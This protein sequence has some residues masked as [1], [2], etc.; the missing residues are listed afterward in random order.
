MDRIQTAIQTIKSGGIIVVSDDENRENEGDFVM[1][2]EAATPEK[3]GFINRHSSGII[4]APIT[5]AKRRSLDLPMMVARNTDPKHTAFTV[6]LDYRHGTSTGISAADRA[7]TLNA[8]TRVSS[9]P[10]DF[11][12]PGHIFPLIAREGGV[13]ARDGHTEAAVDFANLAG[14]EATGVICEVVNDDGS[15]A[16]QPEL[17]V[18]SRAHRLPFV[19]IEDL[20]THRLKTERLIRQLTETRVA[21]QHGEWLVRDFCDKTVRSG[22]RV[23]TQ[24]VIGTGSPVIVL[25]TCGDSS[26]GGLRDCGCESALS[27]A[28]CAIG[29]AGSGCIIFLPRKGHVDAADGSTKNCGLSQIE[30]AVVTQI[31]NTVAAKAAFFECTDAQ[32]AQATSPFGIE[33][34]VRGTSSSQIAK[35]DNVFYLPVAR[36]DDAHAWRLIG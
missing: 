27:A 26:Q 32:L 36:R 29:L 28:I 33:M 7:A 24:G 17:S 19:T 34:V 22:V 35:P 21:N 6:S 20:I 13:L 15:M 31:L 5:E 3:I 23:F 30:A 14:C 9:L 18:L 12:R 11:T 10:G 16:R 4:C 1:A 8:I 25:P 2:A